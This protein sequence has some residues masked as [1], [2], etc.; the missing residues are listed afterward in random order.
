VDN[1]ISRDT[2]D[3]LPNR[4]LRQ[5]RVTFSR[6]GKVL[7][8]N[9]YGPFNDELIEALA[10]TEFGMIADMSAHGKWGDIIEFHDSAHASPFVLESFQYFLQIL[11]KQ[12]LVS[13]ATAIIAAP[14]LDD[15]EEMKPRLIAAYLSNGLTVQVFEE[16]D[17]AM[18]WVAQQLDA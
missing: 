17:E 8:C 9:A 1:Q 2:N 11:A 7:I 18:D 4:K 16:F 14:N 5:G 13:S 12:N 6:Q 3:Y 10:V 15:M